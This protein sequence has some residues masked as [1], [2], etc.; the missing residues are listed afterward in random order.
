MN[1]NLVDKRINEVQNRATELVRL[2]EKSKSSS[3]DLE[4]ELYYASC[5][6]EAVGRLIRGD[7]V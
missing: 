3:E 7:D 4:I 6:I 5:A 2:L 1:N